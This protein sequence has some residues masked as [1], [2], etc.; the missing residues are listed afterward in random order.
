M[1]RRPPRSTLFPY[2]TLFRSIGALIELGVAALRGIGTQT[3]D[4]LAPGAVFLQH[5]LEM[6]GM[7][8]VDHVI[9]RVRSEEHTS[10]LQSRLHLVCRLLLEKKKKTKNMNNHG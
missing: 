8:A 2:T 3:A 9:R 10:E 4:A 5:M 6:A 1:I 7:R